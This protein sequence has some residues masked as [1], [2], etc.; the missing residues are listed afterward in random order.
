MQL[1]SLCAGKILMSKKMTSLS[2]CN[3]GI[4]FLRLI[5]PPFLVNSQDVGSGVQVI[6]T[7]AALIVNI[8][9][10]MCVLCNPN[11]LIIAL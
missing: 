6:L 9:F 4:Q 7:S 1:F 11:F 3:L 5:D 10:K 2:K 8:P